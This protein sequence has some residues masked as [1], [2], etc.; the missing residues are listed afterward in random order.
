MTERCAVFLLIWFR[1]SEILVLRRLHVCPT[2]DASQ[3]RQSILYITFI[4][5]SNGSGSLCTRII[6]RRLLRP[7]NESVMSISLVTRLNLS[8]KHGTYGMLKNLE[9]LLLLLLSCVLIAVALS[10]LLLHKNL[11]RSLSIL[12]IKVNG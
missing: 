10:L 5:E 7:E 3:L 1:C 12:K 9:T 8:E 4:R 6:E 11:S 2:Y